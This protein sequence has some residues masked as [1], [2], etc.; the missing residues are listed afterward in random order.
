MLWSL[1][2]NGLIYLSVLLGVVLLPQLYGAVPS[3]LFYSVLGGWLAY[4]A[5]A[6]A[7]TARFR[8]AYHAAFILAVLTLA[9][10]MPQPAHYFL[11]RAGLSLAST[12]FLVGSALQIALLLLI[13]VYLRKRKRVGRGNDSNLEN[14]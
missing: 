13:P 6:I 4:L 12:T 14:R 10:S 1:A 9:V 8:F 5:V 7:A 3:W 11:L 2:I